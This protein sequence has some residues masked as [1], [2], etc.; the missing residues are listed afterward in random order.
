MSSQELEPQITIERLEKMLDRSLYGAGKAKSWDSLVQ[1]IIAGECRIVWE[2]G[3]PIRQVEFMSIQVNADRD[4]EFAGLQLVEA[5]QQFSDGRRR[6]RG[7]RPVSEKFKPGEDRLTVT[8]RALQEELGFS[9]R[10]VEEI[11]ITL[12][13]AIVRET[14]ES[15]SYPG[16]TT[17]YICHRAIACLPFHLCK[18]EYV[19][20]QP[21]KKT[22]FIWK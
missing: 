7:L 15:P 5:Y 22:V 2:Q 3:Q 11:A 12:D 19:E 18:A 17:Q 10:E 1:E 13:S 21:D 8:K 4:S 6:E 9:A 20:V 16:L 14:K